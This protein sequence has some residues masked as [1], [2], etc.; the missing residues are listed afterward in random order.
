MS[1]IRV[2][3]LGVIVVAFVVSLAS[4][5]QAAPAREEVERILSL[6]RARGLVVLLNDPRC[7]L[8]IALAKSS[9][10]TIYVQL[11][12]DG[13]LAAARAAVAKAGLLGTRIYVEAG[14]TKRIGL[15]DNLADALFAVSADGVDRAEALRV[16][17]PGANAILGAETIV[18][19]A[20][21]GADD[22]TH[23]YH[24]PDNN[25]RSSDRLARGPYLTQFLAE[26]YYGTQPQVTVIAGGR[27][28]RLFGHIASKSREWPMMNKLVA[29][30]AYNGTILWR[31]DLAAGYAIHRNTV[32][33]TA[34][35][36]Y[37]ADGASCKLIDAATGKVTGQITP[38]V[39]KAGGRAWKW[40]AME[41][42]VLFGMIGPAEA[43]EPDVRRDTGRHGWGW[44]SLGKG[45]ARAGAKPDKFPWGFGR[46]VL[47]IDPKTKDILWRHDAD[48]DIDGRA[49]CM[50]GG[51]IYYYCPGKWLVCLDA[52][53][54]NRLWR[55]SDADVL[56]AIGPDVKAQS[57][58]TGYASTAYMKATDKAL[59]FAGP[60]RP[61]VVAVSAANGKLLW[62]AAGG[63]VHLVL[64]A[65][66]VYA[67]GGPGAC[68][69]FDPLKGD[70]IRKH[71]FGRNGC[72]RATGGVDTIFFRSRATSILNVAT[73]RIRSLD[74]M[75][76]P[77]QDGVIIANGL[78]HWGPWMCDCNNSLVGCVTLAPAKAIKAPTSE[79]FQ[80]G[81]KSKPVG[82]KTTAN[83]W[84]SYR[85]DNL[86][87]AATAAKISAKVRRQWQYK[88]SGARATAPVVAGG[89][90]V[91]GDAAGAV[92]A[93][94][95]KTS[96]VR[97]T[98]LTGGA[99]TFPPTIWRG[100][101]Y[102]GSADGWVYC[103]DAAD[104]ELL[105]R[106]RAAPAERKIPVYGRLSSTWPVASG[107]L[108]ADG[109]A[110]AAAGIAN[111]DG[112]HVVALDAGSG[113]LK[114]RNGD[115]GQ[116]GRVS[117]QGGLLLHDGKLHLA[118]GN[119]VSP[120]VYDIKTGKLSTEKRKKPAWDE[121][122]RG[123]DLYLVDGRVVTSGNILYAPDADLDRPQR[124]V[125][126]VMQA[127]AGKFVIAQGLGK[128]G[129]I[130]V[131]RPAGAP[132]KEA[133]PRWRR[134]LFAKNLAIVATANAALVMGVDVPKTG[135]PVFGLAALSLTDGKVIWNRKL[136]SPA[137]PW[138]LA[139]DGGG[140][141][142][143]SLRDGGVICLGP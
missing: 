22:W 114:W 99:I 140:R 19:P 3:V 143:V 80:R 6:A 95:V 123:R 76:P 125:R 64:R 116:R 34:S 89:L 73:G 82:L 115:S 130:I 68:R 2:V 1:R 66:G 85:K 70:V 81:A 11:P 7:G 74:P 32:V 102:V 35:T 117:V 55:S 111:Y 37:L 107:V 98:F 127:P 61:K 105:W 4:W 30:S 20:P 118:G 21:K 84:P 135:Q 23:P 67:I 15:A 24:G 41:G 136:P 113:A 83:D 60:Q 28:F 54:G 110:Y 88:G 97:W 53:N 52:A 96:R 79:V 103:L 50:A 25:P 91:V 77:C 38:P 49:I 124:W 8:A 27:T 121:E 141:I 39:G 48:A 122:I 87:S 119:V 42:G 104:G 75:R 72:A 92:R 129:S 108:V 16:L 17:R 33:A 26:P 109:V 5:A 47:A 126:S 94:D 101:A 142:Y 93:I 58:K 138:G 90:V 78:L 100:R 57:Y 29:S 18:K 46:S 45:Y 63:N 134:K 62:R 132:A 120:A 10:L 137:V 56:A 106:H 86:R 12:R 43:R 44:G 69:V 31:R 9:E 40:L 59:Y 131:A 65:D 139:V 13:D 51:R 112:T 128:D 36:L 133:K 14:P 71:G